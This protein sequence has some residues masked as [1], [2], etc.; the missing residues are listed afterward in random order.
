L[1]APAACCPRPLR[2]GPAQTR[3]SP[4]QSLCV[5][6]VRG[7]ARACAVSSSKALC[8]QRARRPAPQQQTLADA[9]PQHTP[10]PACRPRA[11]RHNPLALGTCLPVRHT[12]THT[13]RRHK[14]NTNAQNTRPRAPP[15][16]YRAM[17][18]ASVPEAS[19]TRMGSSGLAALSSA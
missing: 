16:P 19:R 7:V 14:Q 6:R 5:A 15:S 12:R 4:R 2:P 9:R 10:R 8:G 17:S 3:P 1:P 11:T 13:T 18:L